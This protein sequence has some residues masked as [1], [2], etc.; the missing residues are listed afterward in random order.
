VG[1]DQEDYVKTL[2]DELERRDKDLEAIRSELTGPK[3]SKPADVIK[4]ALL[5]N[6]PEYIA[7][8]DALARAADSESV[9]L[10]ANKLLIEWVVTEKLTTGDSTADQSFR[11]LIAELKKPKNKV[12]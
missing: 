7:N 12:R 5:D 3:S 9:R 2:Q 10:Q 8:L 1:Q 11:D 6:V 4:E